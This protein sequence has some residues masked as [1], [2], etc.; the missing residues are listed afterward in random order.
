MTHP[1]DNELAQLVDDALDADARARIESHLDGCDLCT[2]LVAELA[3][4]VTP[5]RAAPPGYRLIRALDPA[6]FV[7]ESAD[8]TVA[9][10][11]G[12][13]VAAIDHPNVVRIYQSG[14]LDGEPFVATALLDRGPFDWRKALAGLAALHR[15]G[16]LL[17]ITPDHVL[18]DGVVGN[19]AKPVARDSGYLAREV[20][21]GAAPT[22]ASD[23]TS[24][25]VSI[26]E[27][28]TGEK[29]FSGATVG[30]LAVAMSAPPEPRT[31]DRRV[32]SVLARGMHP[33]PARRWPSIDAL[34]AALAKPP[35]SKLP[36]AIGLVV[37]VIAVALLC[38]RAFA[39][40]DPF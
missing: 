26:Y 10:G 5:V 6:T 4:L 12:A 19:F 36:I 7:A 8:G 30:A 34:A 38:Q 16:T 35:R 27:H 24:A 25:C 1:D 39:W 13:R 20:L 21:E 37:L 3:W 18:G 33:D 9:L 28:L 17:A 11:F 31:L 40:S 15:A 23:Q 2:Q 29:P 22:R 32:Y 14:V